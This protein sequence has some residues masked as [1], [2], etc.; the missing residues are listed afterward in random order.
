M[1]PAAHDGSAAGPG[2]R[3]YGRRKGRPLRPGRSALLERLLPTLRFNVP[4]GDGPFR[5]QD[6]CPKP[7]RAVWLEIGFGSGEHLV[8]Q[9]SRNP[10]IG[11]IGAEPFV[12][13]VAKLLAAIERDKLDNISIVDDDVRPL[14]RDIARRAPASI[15]RAF[16]LFPDPWPKSRHH[17]RRIINSETV[18]DLALALE[19]GAELRVASD[20]ADYVAW[21]LAHVLADSAFEW[22]A[23]RPGDWRER[24]DDWPQTRYEAKAIA[25]GRQPAFLRFRRRPR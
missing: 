16:V 18:A 22:L 1:C 11:F 15:G 21:T 13:G 2:T 24:P 5:L 7:V 23:R 3:Y 25:D 14:L 10:E 12:N 19:D 6:L 20:V 17:K 8:W 4:P 9:A